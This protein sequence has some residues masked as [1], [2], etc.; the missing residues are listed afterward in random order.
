LNVMLGS[1]GAAG[2]CPAASCV[3]DMD[4]APSPSA[5]ITAAK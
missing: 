2:F 5:A 3:A 1:F 4:S